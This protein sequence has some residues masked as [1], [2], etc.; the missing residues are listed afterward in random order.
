M[1]SKLRF[2][3]C[4]TFVLLTSAETYAQIGPFNDSAITTIPSTNQVNSTQN[5]YKT[6]SKK[7]S[8]S[9]DSLMMLK[10]SP[11]KATLLSVCLPGA[12]QVYNKKYWK[13]PLVYAAAGA[14]LYGAL[15]NNKYYQDFKEQYAFR[16]ANGFSEDP[17]YTQFQDPTLKSYRDYYHKNRDLSY[18]L[19]GA[20]YILQIVDAAV[21]AHFYDFK[22]TEDLS[23]NV[24][25]QLYWVSSQAQTHLLFTLK[26]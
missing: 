4:F 22:I 2:L 19:L 12:G 14:S 13:V 20:T 18:I 3:L 7:R 1:L 17:Y 24:Q 11:Q 5:T 8:Q 16:V 9:N 25:P 6:P 26:F 23:L 15:W 21:D 10:H